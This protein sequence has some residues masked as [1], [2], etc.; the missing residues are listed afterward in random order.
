MTLRIFFLDCNNVLTCTR[1]N[2]IK[3]ESKILDKTNR[4]KSKP[5]EFAK[6]SF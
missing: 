4:Y 1:N 5:Y 2:K 3:E 6:N